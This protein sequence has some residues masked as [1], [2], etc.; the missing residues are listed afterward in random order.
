MIGIVSA[1]VKGIENERPLG[2]ILNGNERGTEKESAERKE[3][4]HIAAR[5]TNFCSVG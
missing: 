3:N 1:N 5:A 2:G 4:P